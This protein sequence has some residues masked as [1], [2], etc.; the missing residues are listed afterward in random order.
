MITKL[1]AQATMTRDAGLRRGPGAG[2]QAS[3]VGVG[4]GAGGVGAEGWIRQRPPV[5]AGHGNGPG[6]KPYEK[7]GENE[8]GAEAQR[9][10]DG[11]Q[12]ETRGRRFEPE[13]EALVED[14]DIG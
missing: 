13:P 1:V 2:D 4:A 14:I 9:I 10:E 6:P 12:D 8:E 11:G 5:V 7:T 3:R